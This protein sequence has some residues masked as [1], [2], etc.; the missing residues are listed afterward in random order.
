MSAPTQS[1]HRHQVNN[2]T[3]RDARR[4]V[5]VQLAREYTLDL[6]LQRRRTAKDRSES[7]HDVQD[8]LVGMWGVG[9]RMTERRRPLFVFRTSYKLC[10]YELVA[11]L[12]SAAILLVASGTRL[13]YHG[14]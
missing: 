1:R 10:T 7:M 8:T 9:H 11:R 13:R 14:I 12:L 4:L 3:R 2:E 6:R 5:G